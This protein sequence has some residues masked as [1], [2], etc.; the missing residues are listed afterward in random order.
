MAVD[1]D[2]MSGGVRG[3]GR[4]TAISLDVRFTGLIGQLG[5]QNVVK[6]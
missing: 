4:A 3:C 1:I 2:V 6:H 5:N